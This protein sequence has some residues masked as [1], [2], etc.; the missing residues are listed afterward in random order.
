MAKVKQHV[1]FLGYG[2]FIFLSVGYWSGFVTADE[3]TWKAGFARAKITPE[4]PFW[5]AGFAKRT[6]PADGTL[7][8]LWIKVLV[9][10]DA[11]GHVGVVL[12]SDLLG[13]PKGMYEHLFGVLHEKHGL[14]RDQIML[15]ASHTH[16]GPVLCDALYDIYPLDDEQRAR[17]EEYSRFLER[18]IL[19]TV[20]RAMASRSPAT[21]R[22]GL[23]RCDFAVN[24]RTNVETHLPEMLRRGQ[25]PKGPSDDRVPVLAVRHPNGELLAVVF[26]YAAHPSALNQEPYRYSG[27][28]AGISQTALQQK[29]PNAQ[30]MFFQGCGSDQSAAP[31]GTL[32]RCEAMGRQLA[33]SVETVLERPMAPVDPCLRTSFTFVSL[34]FEPVRREALEKTASHPSYPGRWARRL[35]GELDAGKRFARSY[36]EYPVQ[37][38]R[39]G[40]DQLWIALGGEV[41]VEYA[42]WFKRRF[43]PRTW[44]AG[45]TNDVMAYIPS[46]QIWEE[47]GYQ[48]GA[49]EVYGLPAA[50]W[51]P[52][53]Q[54]RIT[55]S[56]ERLVAEELALPHSSAE[57]H[58]NRNCPTLKEP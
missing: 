3:P 25:K 49:F 13:I 9:L 30:A 37:A 43:G 35:L 1:R 10:E 2:T 45:Y 46:R 50:R 54:A 21:L 18:T 19:Q 7:H 17:V 55:G 52:D 38:W 39:L 53:I 27:D 34:A 16:S 44:V 58:T 6:R 33:E 56:V 31:R 26:G 4:K 24:R 14:D 8:D 23:G 5:M 51:A 41:A 36:P 15:T 20:A 48:A 47:G 11:R 32:Q 29:Y 22:A 42:L 28:Y 57:M 12:T 40:N